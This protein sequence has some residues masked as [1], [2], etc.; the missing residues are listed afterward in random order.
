MLEL[1]FSE[2]IDGDGDVEFAVGSFKKPENLKEEEYFDFLRLFGIEP[3]EQEAVGNDYYDG[4]IL[5][6]AEIF[7]ILMDNDFLVKRGFLAKIRAQLQF[8]K[9]L[10]R[11]YPVP[12]YDKWRYIFRRLPKNE[13]G[14]PYYQLTKEFYC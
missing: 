12:G 1:L 9:F 11:N 4:K 13:E 3:E 6:R 5:T 2:M 8:R 14:I 10:K 7:Q